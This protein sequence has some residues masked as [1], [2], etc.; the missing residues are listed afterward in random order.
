MSLNI[1]QQ[2]PSLDQYNNGEIP[3]AYLLKENLN[4]YSKNRLA[5]NNDNLQPITKSQNNKMI[6]IGDGDIIKNHVNSSNQA[7]PLGYNH[8]SKT[9]Y[10]GTNSL[11]STL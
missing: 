1:L 6:I 5:P 10:N 9:Q 3:L 4:R 8:F 7:Y 11:L 2:E